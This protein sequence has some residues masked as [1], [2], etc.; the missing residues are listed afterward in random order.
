MRNVFVIL[1][2]SLALNLSG[3]T[4]KNKI[5]R[6][7]F[8][9]DASGSMKNLW[10]GKPRMERAR[11]VLIEVATKLDKDPN[12]YTA[13]RVY[14]HQYIENCEDSKL[15]VG[16]G[17]GNNTY[18]IKDRLT[19]IRA[20]GTTPISYSLEKAGSDF[21][22]IKARNVVILISDGLE[23]CGGDPCAVS[24]SLQAKKVI[25]KP[26]IIG[27]GV[28]IEAKEAFECMGDFYNVSTTESFKNTINLII[29]KTLSETSVQVNLLDQS[30]KP[31]ETDVNLSFYNIETGNLD[32]N[33]YHSITAAG[34]P[35][36]LTVDPLYDYDMSVHTTP[37]VHINH[38]EIKEG[39]NN[40]VHAKTPQGN[41][42]VKLFST[43]L[44]NN[45]DNKIKCILRQ[46]GKPNTLDIIYLEQKK[47]VITGL[48]DIE[49]LTLPRTIINNVEV[50]Q[51]KTTTLQVPSPGLITIIK[52]FEGYGALLHKKANKVEKIYDLVQNSSKEVIALQPGNYKLI[53]RSKNA[54]NPEAVIVRDFSV[55]SGESKNI[56]L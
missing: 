37:Q 39:I 24:R 34:S 8:I 44:H 36:L 55:K 14:G 16:F 33:Y 26:F 10:Q 40:V 20:R 30:E 45:I 17:T 12:V 38:I 1:M 28:S 23:S 54:K 47:K 22:D 4:R 56:K 6:I 21:P 43:T 11:E 15:E 32:Y 18:Y 35:D 49:I 42:E 19:E 2:C 3:Q 53:Y 52:G 27:L 29:E 48:Y 50:S 41:I 46:A 13:L 7:L 51:S 9:L 31:T 25:L 5:T